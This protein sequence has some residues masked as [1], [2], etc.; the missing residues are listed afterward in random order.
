MGEFT[1]L[2]RAL[3]DQASGAVSRRVVC[4]SVTRQGRT[5]LSNRG[6]TSAETG[7]TGA[8]CTLETVTRFSILTRHCLN[9][10]PGLLASLVAL[11][12]M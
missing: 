5:G 3:Y 10:A 4:M 6:Q 11:F 7:V 1:F 12:F 8:F 9:T 2:S